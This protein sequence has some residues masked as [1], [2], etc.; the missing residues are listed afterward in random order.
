MRKLGSCLV[1]MLGLMSACSV[2]GLTDGYKNLSVAE[3]AVVSYSSRSTATGATLV[4]MVHGRQL[5]EA[6]PEGKVNVVYYFNP[7]C[8]SPSCIPIS[9]VRATLSE[10]HNLYIVARSLN[11]SVL[12]LAKNYKIYGID[13]YYY[14]KKFLH[15]YEDKFFDE[16]TGRKTSHTDT[17]MLYVFRG[18]EFSHLSDLAGLAS[19]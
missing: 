9:S 19:L 6:L 2:S 10:E 5:R 11:T 14:R 16:L 13:K 3:K 4:N 17:L 8:S 15:A 12:L 1:L 7:F 18:K